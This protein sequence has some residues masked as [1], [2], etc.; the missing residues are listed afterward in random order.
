MRSA[1]VLQAMR[2]AWYRRQW[3]CASVEGS[4]RLAAPVL[5]AGAGT[6]RFESEVELGWEWG[7]GFHQGYGYIEARGGESVVSFGEGTHVNNGVAIVSEGPGI[8]IGRRCLIGPGV[9]IYDSDFHPIAAH[10]RGVAAPRTAQ[11]RV[12]DDVFI[13]TAAIVLK[14]VSIGEGS[15][16]GAG[17]VVFADVPAGAIVSGNPAQE[18]RR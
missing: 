4:P 18:L 5:L 9:H 6:I 7:P 15:V 14:G 17:S 8:A 13:G 2:I 3:T 11:V 1:A 12:G 10:E 16:I